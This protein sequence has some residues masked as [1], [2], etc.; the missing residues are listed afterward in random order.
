MALA[1]DIGLQLRKPMTI[2]RASRSEDEGGLPDRPGI[3]AWWIE[4]PSQLPSV[5]ATELPS[6]ESGLLYVGLA[7]RDTN[8]A[9]TLRSRILNQHVGGTVGSSTFRRV[10]ASFLWEDF[11]WHPQVTRAGKLAL[12]KDENYEL[13]AWIQSHLKVS[14]I[15]VEEPWQWEPQVIESLQPPLNVQGNSGHP[16]GPTVRA[17]RARFADAAN[18]KTAE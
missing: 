16:F 6:G 9:A 12:P 2:E 8:S 15:I 11:G 10:L 13:T 18:K 3:Y 17:T 14:W 4:L 1:A 5:P 7:P